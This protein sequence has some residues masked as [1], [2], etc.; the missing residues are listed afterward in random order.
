MH[1]AAGFGPRPT[2]RGQTERSRART[3]IHRRDLR[4]LAPI[5][6]GAAC[7]ISRPP[8]RAGG[9][10]EGADAPHA[11]HPPP[12]SRPHLAGRDGTLDPHR[13][14]LWSIRH[15]QLAG[16]RVVAGHGEM[17]GHLKHHGPGLS[18]EQ[19]VRPGAHTRH[20]RPP[21]V[22]GEIALN[23]F[24]G[25]F[26]RWLDARLLCRTRNHI[27]QVAM[28]THCPGP[29]VPKPLSHRVLADMSLENP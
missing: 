3:A 1:R 28:A 15:G 17:L 7:A 20:I 2:R 27:S 23:Q 13:L 9:S 19:F 12:N 24:P 18:G 16:D 29:P 11:P 25:V 14:L 5:P 26:G 6:R 22:A 8:R 21:V 4:Q 10:G